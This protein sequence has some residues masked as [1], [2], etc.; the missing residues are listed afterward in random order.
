MP[1]YASFQILLYYLFINHTIVRRSTARDIES[2]VSKYIEVLSLTSLV[3][4]TLS[5]A[6]FRYRQVLLYILQGI[7]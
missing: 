5:L 4:I 1:G 3:K 7:S 6:G 2:A